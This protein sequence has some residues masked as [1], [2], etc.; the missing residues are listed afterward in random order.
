L[1]LGC[2]QGGTE[3]FGGAKEKTV[4]FSL[5]FNSPPMYLGGFDAGS[6]GGAA[7]S[8]AVIVESNRSNARYITNS[9]DAGYFLWIAVG[10]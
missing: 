8:I 4:N 7:F 1:L 6:A 3:T 2:N 5:S 9:T 10:A